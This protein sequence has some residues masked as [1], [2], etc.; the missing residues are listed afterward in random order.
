[1]NKIASKVQETP[2]DQIDAIFKELSESFQSD[3]T[4]SLSFRKTMLDSFKRGLEKYE[5]E[6]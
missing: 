6:I 3:R 1:M 4:L 2:N 5:K